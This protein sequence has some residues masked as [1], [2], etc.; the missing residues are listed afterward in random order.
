MT[1]WITQPLPEYAPVDLDVVQ[2][3]ALAGAQATIHD[4]MVAAGLKPV[5]LAK[6]LGWHR[7]TVSRIMNGQ[8]NLT[9]KTFALALAG[10]GYKLK[11][12]Y[13]P[14]RW[15]WAAEPVAPT[16]ETQPAHA[17]TKPTTSVG[18]SVRIAIG[19]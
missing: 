4:A 8:H 18:I 7:S 10:C 19:A 16:K 2:E 17:S 5:E 14:L 12:E 13:A 15:R 1:Q 3:S 9:V 6:K 11:F